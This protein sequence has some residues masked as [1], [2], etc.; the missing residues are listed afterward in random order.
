VVSRVARR[1]LTILLLSPI[2]LNG[3]TTAVTLAS[4]ANPAVLGS[5]VTLTATVA[6]NSAAGSVT[7]YDGASILG[8]RTLQN[9]QA[10]LTTTF[11]PAGKRSLKAYYG[12]DAGNPPTTSALVPEIINAQP[13]NGFLTATSY[14]VG[15][16]PAQTSFALA[17]LNGD[18][19]AD[20]LIP[21]SFTMKVDILYGNGDGT[22]KPVVQYPVNL[23]VP[24]IATGDFNGDG[25]TDI[26]T[27][28]AVLLGKGDGTFQAPIAMSS[29]VNV[30]YLVVADF[31]G[32]GKADVAVSSTVSGEPVMVLL[33]NGD[34]TFQA[35]LAIGP[36]LG[37]LV[38]DDFN[39]DGIPDIA[40]GNNLFLGNGDGSFRTPISIGGPPLP[41]SIVRGDFNGDGTPDIALTSTAN[42]ITV[43]L[44]NG[45]GSFQ[46]AVNYN[47]PGGPPTG[48]AVGDL[49]GDGYADL[50]T[51]GF[52]LFGN[53]DGTFQRGVNYFTSNFP[54][55]ILVADFN[56]DGKSDIAYVGFNFNVIVL[57][58]AQLIPTTVSLTP[59]TNPS[60]YLQGVSL[61]AAVTAASGTAVPVGSI[62][63]Y[64]A[65]QAL[66]TV[67]LTNGQAMAGQNLTPG[68]YALTASYTGDSTHAASASAT[69]QQIVN[70]AITTTSF[71]SSLNPASPGRGVTLVATVAPIPPGGTVSFY[72]GATFL[73]TR[74][75]STSGQAAL[76]TRFDTPGAYSLTAIY[77]GTT[78]YSGSTSQTLTEKV[79]P[80][81]MPVS[82]LLQSSANPV[83]YGFPMTL[84]ARAANMDNAPA[85]SGSVTFYD[86]TT[87]LGISP[88]FVGVAS[89]TT[90][91]LSPGT[92]SL[93]AY[94]SG[95]I[96]FSPASSAAVS[97]IVNAAQANGF[98]APSL[99]GTGAGP[100]ALVV[101]DV[102]NDGRSDL[103]LADSQS[104]GISV[105]L[106]NGDGTF[107]PAV[108]YKT[109]GSPQS[110]V[111]GDFNGDG[112]PDVATAGQDGTIV[113][114]L[115]N[116]DGTFQAKTGFSVA[117]Y[118]SYL[119]AADF[120]G[121]GNLDLV[122]AAQF[123]MGISVLLGNGDG[124]FQPPMTYPAANGVTAMIVADFNGDGYSDVATLQGITPTPN[125]S[126]V[127]ILLGNG[128][129]S[130]RP[131]T[132]F[133]TVT[134]AFS[135]V[136]ADFNG[137]GKADLVLTN[138]T[139]ANTVT[140]LLGNGDG[141]FQ[142]GVVYGVEAQ[143]ISVVAADFNGDGKPDIATAND[144][145]AV[146]LLPGNGDGTFQPA[147]RYGTVISPRAMAIGEF[148]G[149][150]RA[151]LAVVDYSVNAV[152]VMLGS[153]TTSTTVTLTS[154]LNPSGYGQV[155]VLTAVLSPATATG[156][157]A[158]YDGVNFLGSTAVIQGQATLSTSLLTS[159]QHSFRAAYQ[160]DASNSPGTS[161]ALA[162]TVGA[163][164]AAVSALTP[165]VRYSA[166]FDPQSILIVDL[167]GDGKADF[168]VANYGSVAGSG[169]VS[170]FLGNGDGTFQAAVNYPTG[171]GA[172]S[173]AAGDFNGD[174]KI[175]L[176]VANNADNSVSVLLGNGDGT[177]QPAVN[178]AAGTAPVWLVATDFNGDGR[179][180]LA[181]IDFGVNFQGMVSIF[182]GN[183]DGSFRSGGTYAAGSS[184]RCAA[185]GDF[186]HD[187]KADLAMGGANGIVLQFGNGD[188]T[189]VGPLYLGAGNTYSMAIG[190][191]N[192]DGEPI[193]P[194]PSTMSTP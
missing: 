172:A 29:G 81:T 34:G 85:G 123:N 101:T 141:S 92:H 105:L 83:A 138:N 129:G 39:G 106:G 71:T 169:S 78:Y 21:D 43:L 10:N 42:G 69:L 121:D 151:D 189:F 61:T 179:P 170:V 37:P 184:V 125:A 46:P 122:A 107:Q 58:G 108:S 26:V 27:G 11:L 49:N 191:F 5:A 118:P 133:S 36:T 173:I 155:V 175:D 144:N 50:V 14:Q 48:I 24:A 72:N 74:T 176:A 168:V 190:D 149:D 167:N 18:G 185:V 130:F 44:G 126:S 180:D 65:T 31:N 188:G 114:L 8:T 187:G 7:F 146:T 87:V 88:V 194:R 53:G 119:A 111:V 153:F 82:V 75:L 90:R 157:V 183:G 150:G 161:A 79:G 102:N 20:L 86:G 116:G 73:G 147:L 28:G 132:S 178:F 54:A 186:N 22:F 182:L 63:F 38:V 171:S 154:S 25:S 134:M 32:D 93:T 76:V 165:T 140:V 104:G 156:R 96:A 6:P 80:P 109:S 113:L 2:F 3:A 177:F 181:V 137:D 163:S 136:T 145:G 60:L 19:K 35:R 95:D 89:L 110:L 143:P 135:L 159:G 59:A 100:V 148:N 51:S 67:P 164:P 97:Q 117:S 15:V 174:G 77:N 33:G 115:G 152:T 160:G 91:F 98:Q 99:Y 84:T 17:D 139:T 56:G 52:V 127:T 120:D 112:K 193:S 1:T 70:N 94:Y 57:L 55:H 64:A 192:G 23:P 40:A 62:T 131:P 9:G 128:D 12:G 158:F 124:S 41:S 4:S 103:V 142:N 166:G 47:N 13:A 162:Q 16:V 68:Q 30:N 45:D 66:Q